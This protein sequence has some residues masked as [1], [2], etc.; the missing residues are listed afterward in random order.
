MMGPGGA[1]EDGGLPFGRVFVAIL[2]CLSPMRCAE[3]LEIYMFPFLMASMLRCM[4]NVYV[5][6]CGQTTGIVNIYRTRLTT[7]MVKR[8]RNQG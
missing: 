2:K 8:L 5:L 1:S 3:R 7:Y 6:I 4:Y